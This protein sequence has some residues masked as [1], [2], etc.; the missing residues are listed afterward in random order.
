M[1]LT[2]EYL[3]MLKQKALTENTKI[4][5]GSNI[6]NIFVDPNAMTSSSSKDTNQKKVNLSLF[7]TV[8]II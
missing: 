2:Q 8:N 1:I 6:P 7:F 5:F 3:E 4:Y